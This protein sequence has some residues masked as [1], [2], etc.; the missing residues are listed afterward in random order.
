MQREGRLFLSEHEGDAR[1]DAL[2]HLRI[3]EVGA[4]ASE[5]SAFGVRTKDAPWPCEIELRAPD[6]SRLRIDTPTE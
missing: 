2:V 1:P 4:I 5:F 3:H 6:G